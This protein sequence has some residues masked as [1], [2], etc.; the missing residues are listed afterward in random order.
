M[1]SS[2]YFLFFFY[3]F[4]T[5]FQILNCV[6]YSMIIEIFQFS[7]TR[8]LPRRGGGGGGSVALKTAER[9]CRDNGEVSRWL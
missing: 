1:P 4:F 2:Q 6:L 8:F 3:F 7:W 5:V 9:C